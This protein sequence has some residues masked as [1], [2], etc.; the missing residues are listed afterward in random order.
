MSFE[1]TSAVVANGTELAVHQTGDGD[2]LVFVH[3]GVSDLRTWSGQVDAFA[4]HFQTILYSRRYHCPNEAIQP[5]APDPIQTHVEDLSALITTL[6]VQ[7]AHLIGH[8]WGGLIALIC[9]MQR[10]EIC[11]SLVLIEPPVVSMHVSIP[12]KISQMIRLFVSSPRLAIGI[13]KLGGGA[14][15]P[16]EKAFRRGDDKAAIELFGRGVLGDKAFD[17]LSSE[18][19]QQVWDNRG[20]D[21]AQA[22]FKGFPDLIGADFSGVECPVLLV[23]GGESPAIFG[24]LMDA[25]QTRLPSADRCVIQ[26]ASHIVHED[27]PEELFSA[28]LGFLGQIH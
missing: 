28:V 18:R 26:G 24:L 10:P 17:S 7:P 22:L 23:S 9:A 21:R 2:P 15:A 4:E 3:G 25:L 8:S 19:Y 5:D 12:P 14:L 13:A 6:N 20:P 11:R 1:H 16:A 27:A